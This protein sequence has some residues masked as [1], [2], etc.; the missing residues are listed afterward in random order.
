MRLV[1]AEPK[2][3]AQHADALDEHV[4]EQYVEFDVYCTNPN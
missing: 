2:Q 3:D 4:V 1:Q